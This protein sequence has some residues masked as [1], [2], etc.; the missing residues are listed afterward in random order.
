MVSA[1]PECHCAIL[2]RTVFRI[3]TVHFLS[4]N[5]RQITQVQARDIKGERPASRDMYVAY[6]LTSHEIPCW[7]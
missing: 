1:G 5:E 7:N 4:R 6:G 2:K 3:E